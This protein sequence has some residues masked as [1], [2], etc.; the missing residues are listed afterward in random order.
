MTEVFVGIDLGGT[1]IKLGCFTQDL[2]LIAKTSIPTQLELGLDSILDR[3]SQTTETLLTKS[4]L[5]HKNIRAAGIGSPGPVD[6]DA[7]IVITT[8][9][10]GFKNVPLRQMLS[11]RLKK[12][13]VLENDANVTC[14]A[15]YVAGAGKGTRDMILLAL[16]TGIGGGVI[17]NGELVH[18]F[19]NNAGELGH[20][21]VHPN[22]R[23]CGCGQKGCAEAYASATSTAARAAEAIHNG[24]KSTLKNVLQQNGQIT[25]KDVYDHSAAG[26][27][28]AKEI[29][30]GT[31][32]S[33]AILCVSL[34]HTTGPQR[35][36]FYGGMIG[37]GSLLLKPLRYYFDR[38]IW[39]IRKEKVKLCFAKLG[40][41]AG[42]IGTAALAAHTHKQK[43]SR[44]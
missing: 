36:V 33:L 20:V 40:A 11:D 43:K 22:G 13:V 26:D 19:D 5:S 31:A 15:E 10:M 9:N 6:V 44:H 7:G 12:P 42:I 41:D 39:N 18:G 37:A 34:L 14:W 25:G 28:L 29:T 30:D 23:L 4:N 24:A 16:G 38:Q 3:I 17:S 32:L 27:K 35:I 21:I 2:T 8:S 1:N